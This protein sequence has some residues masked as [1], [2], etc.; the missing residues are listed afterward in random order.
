[1]YPHS[2]PP[3]VHRVKAHQT[4]TSDFHTGPNGGPGQVPSQHAGKL[5]R[6]IVFRPASALAT[7][8]A[9]NHD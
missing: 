6:S 1:M 2:Q 9:N 8:S 4:E 7:D 3:L 5:H